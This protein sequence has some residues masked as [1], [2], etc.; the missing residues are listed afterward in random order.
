MT[1]MIDVERGLAILF[2]YKNLSYFDFDFVFKDI[3][4]L[5]K[6]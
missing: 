1:K 4:V 2:L 5:T 6:R 3:D